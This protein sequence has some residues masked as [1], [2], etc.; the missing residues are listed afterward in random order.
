MTRASTELPRSPAEVEELND[1]LA[2]EHDIDAYYAASGALIG[3]VEQRRLAIIRRMVGP[4]RGARILEVGCGGGH[5]LQQFSGAHL[6]G[7]D[8]SG[9]MLDKARKNLAGHDVTLLKGQ[10]HELGLRERSFDVVI[11]TEVLEHVVDPHAVLEPMSR[12]VRLGGRVV[13]T[14][15]NDPLIAAIKRGVVR[16]GLTRL[17]PLRRV[18]WGGDHFHLHTWTVGEMRTLLSG[19]FAL[20]DE[21]FSPSRLL[22]I[23][24]CFRGTPALSSLERDGQV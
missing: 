14:F 24:C 9:A 21:A 22:P 17:P 4:H 3:F 12:L 13:V 5:V 11:C 19:Y 15:P 8:V 20:R 23:R 6:T 10:L 1:R 18:E 16:A 2:R 7:V